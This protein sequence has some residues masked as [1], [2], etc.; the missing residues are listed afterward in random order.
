MT[1]VRVESHPT[2]TGQPGSVDPEKLGPEIRSKLEACVRQ[3]AD[4][5]SAAETRWR[6]VGR[7]LQYVKD[8]VP[9]FKAYCNLHKINRSEAYRAMDIAA[10][11]ATLAVQRAKAAARKAKQRVS[12][13][14]TDN[15]RKAK[16]TSEGE[17]LL[18][19]ID[20]VKVV[21]LDGPTRDLLTQLQVAIAARLAE[22]GPTPDA[23]ATAV[24]ESTVLK[25]PGTKVAFRVGDLSPRAKA[26]IT[27]QIGDDDGLDLRGTFL[28]RNRTGNGGDPAISADA[29]K[30]AFSAIEQKDAAH[31]PA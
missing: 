25:L 30:A 20:A 2:S 14:V 9:S 29:M 16:A 17:R 21:R 10:G 6:E 26:Q 4:A 1:T 8:R 13:T 11:K 19:A 18:A 27:Q 22:H 15:R 23:A 24:E 5:A 12:V 3:D 28:D 7:L 31:V